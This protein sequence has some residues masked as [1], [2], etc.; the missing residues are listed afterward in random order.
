MKKIFLLVMLVVSMSLFSAP[1][2]NLPYTIQQPDGTTIDC[3]ASGDEYFNWLHDV[4]GYTIIRGSGG[5]Y[6]Y[7]ETFDGLV[8][9]T[10]FIVGQD[11]P[12]TS[13]IQPWAKI[14]KAEYKK[15]IDAMW[16][17][18]NALKTD[19]VRAPHDGTMNNIVI[20]IRFADDTEFTTTRQTY[21]DLLNPT[22][23]NTL[24]SYFLEA[25][26]NMLTISST[27][28]PA[29]AMTTNVSYQD[30]HNRNYFQPY[31][32]STN[33]AG[34][35]SETER[36]TREHALLRDAINWVNANSAVPAGLNI[37]ADNDGY[38][39]NVCFFVRGNSGGWA[40]LLWAHRWALYTYN[41]FINGKQVWDYTFQ[42]QNQIG[43]RTLCHEMFHALG[44][45]DL[46][47]YYTD[48]H[49]SP[50][51]AWDLMESGS[52]HMT[53]YMKWK[54]T[55]NT[56]IASIP[57]ITTS[58]T[59]TLN[60]LSS[61]TNNCYKIASP[62]SAT[63]YFVVEYRQKTGTFE[64]TV[65]GSGLIVYRINPAYD[66]NADGPPDELYIYRP[67]GTLSANGTPNTAHFSAGTGRTTINDGTNPSSFLTNGSAGGL[68][69]WGV[70]TAGSTIS[71]NVGLADTYEVTTTSSPVGGG[72]LTGAGTYFL[73]DN[74]TVTA[75]ANPGYDF[76]DWTDGGT[77]VSTNTSFS[78]TITQDR[79]LVANF[80]SNGVSCDTLDNTEAASASN[81][82]WSTYWGYVSGHSGRNWTQFAE[83]FTAP[84]Q[85]HV[86][87]LYVAVSK[88][89]DLNLESP[90]VF[91][92]YS[93]GAMPGAV[94]GTKS[95]NISSL[96]A[97]YWNYIEFDTPILTS[98][99]YFIGYE[100]SYAAPNDQDTFAVYMSNYSQ[101]TN[102]TAY[103]YTSTGWNSYDNLITSV[104]FDSH[105]WLLSI[106][107]TQI[108]EVTLQSSPVAGGVVTGDGS[109][110]Y[111]DLVTVF[112]SPNSGY[113]FLN[114]TEGAVVVS[115]NQTYQFNATTDRTLTANFEVFT[116]CEEYNLQSVKLY[117]NPVTDKLNLEGIPTGTRLVIADI[118]GKQV[119]AEYIDSNT[120]SIDVSEFTNGV[121]ILHFSNQGDVTTKK[122]VKQ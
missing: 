36:R 87:G 13:G 114:W 81:Y 79:D 76:V 28:Y 1:I 56:W 27:H 67:G 24:K 106:N 68:D 122:I 14:S 80:V 103:A 107:C 71:F 38:V 118:A 108:Y 49:I 61:S 58:G 105:L 75:T 2:Y 102:N 35:A 7:G 63:E 20:Y 6:Y 22:T 82:T 70:T 116:S 112:A 31:D 16:A 94:L 37:D 96:S 66:G 119:Y 113:S 73:N 111:N 48:T 12:A 52:G 97:G 50:A 115:T 32:A 101:T 95:V 85:P 29:C 121:Y 55:D 41:V 9:P 15:R 120:V 45:P 5:W 69:I 60:P 42:P 53:A 88:A 99:D 51:G 90:V 93:G 46:Y 57:E 100:I 43:V 47:H 18:V 26:Y 109:Y 89:N 17:E 72:I 54:Y 77:T 98:G 3:F 34:Y 110:P 92:V 23:G 91:K 25:S 8:V 86:T 44:A 62:N 84:P 40:E 78:F 4:D 19:P 39:D 74:V 10:Q 117:P 65:P 59:Y 104:S 64:G 83:K 33:P 30:S 11:N 21:D